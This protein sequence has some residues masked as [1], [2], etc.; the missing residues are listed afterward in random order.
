MTAS[1]ATRSG[2]RLKLGKGAL[3]TATVTL[4]EKTLRTM[5]FDEADRELADESK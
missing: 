3:A 5:G 2:N 4:S 1:T